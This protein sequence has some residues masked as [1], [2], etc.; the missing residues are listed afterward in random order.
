MTKAYC[1][2]QLCSPVNLRFNKLIA[3]EFFYPQALEDGPLS[4][5]LNIGT[6]SV[7]ELF[8]NEVARGEK[9]KKQNSVSSLSHS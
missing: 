3:T 4:N 9:K 7:H 6:H 2:V 5:I 1:Q 8:W